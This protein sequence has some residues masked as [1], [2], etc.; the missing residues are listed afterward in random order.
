MKRTLI[1]KE[2]KAKVFYKETALEVV[3]FEEA[4]VIGFQQIKEVYL[5]Q[6]IAIDIKTVLQIAKHVKVTL[7][8][9]RGYFTGEVN[10]V[11]KR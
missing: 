3:T 2:P 7:I 6:D 4:F 8:D 1:V 10:Y 5:H 9:K 11:G